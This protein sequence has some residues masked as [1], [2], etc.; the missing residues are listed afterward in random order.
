MD[1]APKASPRKDTAL[2][3][4]I[5][6]CGKLVLIFFL[7]M[8]LGF[9]LKFWGDGQESAQQQRETAAMLRWACLINATARGHPEKKLEEVI[10]GIQEHGKPYGVPEKATVRVLRPEERNQ[11]FHVRDFVI[12]KPPNPIG[13]RVYSDGETSSH[14]GVEKHLTD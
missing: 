8:V 1:A 12:E 5:D 4:T 3:R 7:L 11:G 10:Q 6:G 9:A 2:D 14:E 13:I